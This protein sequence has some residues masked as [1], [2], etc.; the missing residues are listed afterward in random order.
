VLGPVGFTLFVSSALGQSL[1]GG[2]RQSLA[3]AI[4]APAPAQVFLGNSLDV[5]SSCLLT[6]FAAR[7][8]ARLRR[9]EGSPGWLSMAALA[10]FILGIAASLTDK[11]AFSALATQAGHGLEVPEAIT[12]RDVTMVSANLGFLYIG[13]L[14]LGCAA[15]VGLRASAFPPWLSWGGAAIAVVNLVSILV[16]PAIAFPRLG[17]PLVFLWLLAASL[18]LLVRPET[19]TAATAG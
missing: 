3:A 1:N 2:S 12:L 7:L 19:P 17:F 14:F 6:V 11:I 18:V 15:A 9:A 13:I 8:W 16:P 4:A 10:G 5:L